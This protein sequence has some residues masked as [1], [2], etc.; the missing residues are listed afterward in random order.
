MI[1]F[2]LICIYLVCIS[3]L[4]A[5]QPDT[6]KTT[7]ERPT[8][9]KE[10]VDPP[11]SPYLNLMPVPANLELKSG[12]FRLDKQFSILVTGRTHSRLYRGATRALSRL[13]SRTGLFL[14]RSQVKPQKDLTEANMIITV[15]RPGRVRLYE[16]ESYTLSIRDNNIE[17]LF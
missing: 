16:D 15:K 6:G 12:K 17:L 13:D 11:I 5:C 10:V 4:I 7:S 3:A 8:H 14:E 9:E 2:R 1:T